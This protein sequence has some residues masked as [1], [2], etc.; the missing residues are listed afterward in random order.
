VFGTDIGIASTFDGGKTWKYRGIAKQT[1]KKDLNWNTSQNTFWAPDI[2]YDKTT[3]LYHMYA[4]ITPGILDGWNEGIAN[5]VHLSAKDP[6]NGWSYD[7]IPFKSI[8]GGID[9]TVHKLDDGKW[10]LWLKNRDRM[11]SSDLVNWTS[12]GTFAAQTGE[13][14]YV[15]WWKGYYWMIQDPTSGD[16]NGGLTVHRSTDGNTWQSQA[17]ILGGSGTRTGEIGVDGKH[18]SVVVQS[19]KAYVFYFSE[20][21]SNPT[22]SVLQ[23]APLTVSGTGELKAN[24]DASF[25]LMLHHSDDPKNLGR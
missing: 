8:H 11:S 14:P 2:I 6:L 3:Q 1:G 19:D 17:N 7:A 21:G 22:G 15:F 25:E 18:C 10:Y 4:S 9:P 12:D 5:V 13:A 16:A 23:A 24:R 20:G